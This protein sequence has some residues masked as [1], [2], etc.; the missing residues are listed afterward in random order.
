MGALDDKVIVII[1][2]TTGMGLSGARAF[3]AAG[4]KGIVIV[5]RTPENC[6]AAL[7]VLGSRVRASVGDATNP[8]TATDAIAMAQQEFGDFHGLYHVAG[9]SGRR[10]GDG[11]LHELTDEGWSKTIEWNLTSAMYSSRAAVQAMLAQGRGGAVVILGSILGQSPSPQFFTTH[12]YAAAKSAVLGFAKAVAANYAAD[13]IRC[14]V[15]VPSLVATPMSAR[16][17]GDDAVLNFIKTKQPLDGG[18]IGQPEDLDAAAVL[19]ISDGGK[20]ITGQVLA[21]DGGW[22]VSEGQY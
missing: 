22:E 15:L 7:K 12:A 4:A 10:F 8:Q 20:F 17:A 13:N 5:G 9:G 21:V 18:R 16:V 14:N 11:P 2:G 1:G 3:L 19:L 6:A